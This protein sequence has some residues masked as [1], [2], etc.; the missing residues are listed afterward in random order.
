MPITTAKKCFKENMRLCADPDKEPEKY[1][2]YSGLVSL[3][4]SIEELH[5]TV[6]DIKS[7]LHVLGAALEKR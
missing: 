6:N 4:D 1:N 3:A 5:K 7:S 2:L